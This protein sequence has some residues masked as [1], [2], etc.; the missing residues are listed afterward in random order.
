MVRT[1]H[2]SLPTAALLGGSPPPYPFVTGDLYFLPK[3][4]SKSMVLG[5]DPLEDALKRPS[6]T[7]PPSIT[8]THHDGGLPSPSSYTLADDDPPLPSTLP[9]RSRQNLRE[10]N[11][12]QND[13]WTKWEAVQLADELEATQF[14][15]KA[16]W[17]CWKEAQ[18]RREALDLEINGPFL[19]EWDDLS[20]EAL[21]DADKHLRQ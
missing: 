19:F 10:R 16:D 21:R 15:A 11:I 6:T 9:K 17:K 1:N 12:F 8:T 18:K 3:I 20:E 4:W 7:I 13:G 2:G 14:K 5:T